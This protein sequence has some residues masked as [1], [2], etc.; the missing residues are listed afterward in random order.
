M[1]EKMMGVMTVVLG[2]GAA[3]LVS[4]CGGAAGRSLIGLVP[5]AAGEELVQARRAVVETGA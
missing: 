5:G 1:V 3:A 4:L 2:L